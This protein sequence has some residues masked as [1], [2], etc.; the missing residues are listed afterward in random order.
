MFEPNPAAGTVHRELTTL[1]S[2]LNYC[3]KEGYILNAPPVWL[4]ELPPSKERLLTRSEAARLLCAAY[5]LPKGRHLAKFILLSLYIGTRKTAVL[6]L[7]FQSNTHGGW[8]DTQ[9]GILYRR[10]E[11][12]RQTAKRRPP[13]PV[14]TATYSRTPDDGKN[15]GL[16]MLSSGTAQP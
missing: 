4:P 2:T 6:N 11:K 12:E 7:R 14:C 8:I 9:Q 10:G 16:G 1:R 3:H 5:R 15:P 13:L